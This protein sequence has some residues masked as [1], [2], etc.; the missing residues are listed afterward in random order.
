[1]PTTFNGFRANEKPQMH[2]SNGKINEIIMVYCIYLFAHKVTRAF[3]CMHRFVEGTLNLEQTKLRSETKCSYYSPTLGPISLY[4]KFSKCANGG[5][6]DWKS[7]NICAAAVSGTKLSAS[8]NDVGGTANKS[9][10]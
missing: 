7:V 9:F 2:C 10:I 8:F 6:V 5:T 1:M 3:V 4:D